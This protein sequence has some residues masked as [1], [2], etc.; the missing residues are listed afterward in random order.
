LST[1][2]DSNGH[3][4]PDA[5]NKHHVGTGRQPDRVRFQGSTTCP[6]CGG[7]DD[8]PRGEGK[9]CFGFTQGEW[10]FCTREDHA[11]RSKLS[12]L[13]ASFPHKLAG[14]CPCGVEHAPA[15]GPVKPVGKTIEKVYSYRDESGRVVHETVRYRLSN[16][17]KKFSQRRPTGPSQHEWNLKGIQT[18]LYRLPELLKAD[19]DQIVFVVEGEKDVDRLIGLKLVATCNPMG[20]EKWKPHFGGWLKDRWVVALVDNDDPGRR[21]GGQVVGSLQGVAKEVRILELPGLPEK[22]DVS[23]WLDEG[24]TADQLYELARSAFVEPAIEDAPAPEPPAVTH[25]QAEP[26]NDPFRIARAHLDADHAHDDMPT[27]CRHRDAWLAWDGTAWKE[28][29]AGEI[30]AAVTRT[31]KREFDAHNAAAKGSAMTVSRDVVANA[32]M[33]LESL[34]IVKGSVHQPSWFGPAPFPENEVLPTT[35]A[36][37][38]L[39][40]LVAGRPYQVSATPRFFCGHSLGYGFDEKAPSPKEWLKFLG[41]VWPRDP[42]S[43]DCLQEWFGYCLLQDTSQQKIMTLIGPKR[44]GKGTIARILKRL[45]GDANVAS[46]TCANLASHFGLSPLVGKSL[47]IIGDAR[48]AGGPEQSIVVERLLTISGE[49]S[50]DVDRKYATSSLTLRLPTRFM[51]LSNDAP[52]FRDVSGA[53]ISRFLLLRFRNT[54]YGSEDSTLEGRLQR[55]LPGIL[56]WAIEGWR[57]L[58]ERG[59]FVQPDEGQEML[60]AAHDAGSP[61]SA[62]VRDRIAIED[63]S[64]E[65]IKNVFR[66]W[67][68][69]C[70]EANRKPG[71]EPNFGVK[72]RSVIPSLNPPKQKRVEGGERV[73]YYTGIRLKSDF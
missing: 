24:G 3:V 54:V 35:T 50:V 10:A 38:H 26:I 36:I 72:L 7:R 52:T 18:V 69:W 37:I 22:G 1:V 63:D 68:D 29:S 11:G 14:K 15:G 60:D 19:P 21:H 33:A 6:I 2:R 57:R 13:T 28:V 8:D 73:R 25:A 44:S 56:L 32:M 5:P 39:P 20:A 43:I 4:K 23:D 9:R 59:R 17:D 55:E 48:F 34:V 66:A 49:D 70:E 46:P 27:L 64:Q 41:W 53:L 31:A 61:I 65:L 45:L 30:K 67:K 12:T 16:G 62:F 42:Q 47:A 51:L 40:S 58:Q 71:D